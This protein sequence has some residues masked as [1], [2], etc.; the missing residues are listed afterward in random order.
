MKET[1][2]STWS[3]T[4]MWVSFKHTPHKNW[5]L[6]PLWT[7]R[8]QRIHRDA[9]EARDLT[10]ATLVTF[11][12]SYWFKDLYNGLL[13]LIVVPIQWLQG[14]ISLELR[15]YQG[16]RDHW[17]C[18]V[19]I[20]EA[21]IPDQNKLGQITHRKILGQATCHKKTWAQKKVS[22]PWLFVWGNHH[23]SLTG[24]VS[25]THALLRNATQL[26]DNSTHSD[27]WVLNGYTTTK[28]SFSIHLLS[29]HKHIPLRHNSEYPI[30][31]QVVVI[32]L[33]N[34]PRRL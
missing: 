9:L 20:S 18:W 24:T 31:A 33:V 21:V 12:Q 5:R 13:H 11:N 3:S 22:Y 29:K 10:E 8:A 1:K 32:N 34:I 16:W 2:A 4:R 17:F 7:R 28:P 30:H 15:D 23:E 6:H 27:R 25:L 14:S 19:Y 26:V